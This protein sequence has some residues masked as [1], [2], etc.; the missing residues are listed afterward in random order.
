M[1]A[2]VILLAQ[3]DSGGGDGG[4]MLGALGPILP[5]ILIFAAFYF[6][7]IMPMKRREKRDR[8]DLLTKLKKNDE[9][10]TYSGI[11]GIVAMVKDNDEVVLKVDESSNV[12]L[13]ILKSSIVRIIP[14]KEPAKEGATA[15]SAQGAATG[16]NVKAGT[17]PAK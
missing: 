12:R 7:V 14:P 10:V 16:D 8:E 2:N 4:G 15:A 13:R 6:L 1:F 5:M 3:K 11:I 17:P 9:V